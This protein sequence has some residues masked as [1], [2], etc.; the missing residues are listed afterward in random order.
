M[1]S[2]IIDGVKV[3]SLK[4]IADERGH[5]MELVRRDDPAFIKFGQVY[6]TTAFPGVVKGWHYHKAQVDNFA[7]VQGQIKLVLFDD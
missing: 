3:K 2:P 7:C 5:L 4:P 6:M 1:S